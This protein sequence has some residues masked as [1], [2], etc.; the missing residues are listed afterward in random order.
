MSKVNREWVFWALVGVSISAWMVFHFSA[1]MACPSNCYIDLGALHG[2]PVGHLELD[3]TRLNTWILAWSQHALLTPGSSLFDANALYPAA[4]TLAGSEHLLG[5]ALVT[6]PLRAFTDNAV[7]IYGVALMTS[8][9]ILAFSTVLCVRWLLVSQTPSSLTIAWAAGLIAMAMPWRMAE[10][11]HIQLLWACWFP[12]IFGLALRLL[13]REG[14]WRESGILSVVLTLQLLSSYYLAYM[15]TLILGITTLV[16]IVRGGI[17]RPSLL[18]LLPPALIPYGTLGFISIPYLSRSA[19]GEISVTLDPE[20]PMAGDHLGNVIDMLLPR[21]NTLWQQNAGFETTYFIPASV[22]ALALLSCLWFGI[23]NGETEAEKP[24]SERMRTIFM[25]LWISCGVAFTMTLGSHIRL[26]ESDF[27]LPSYWAAITLP[28][29]SNL[30]APHRWAIV[31]GTLMPL[32]AA[33]GAAGLIKR[34]A[35]WKAGK[36]WLALI[37]GALLFINLPWTQL[38][39]LK[40]FEE[41]PARN[42]LYPKLR[43]LPYGPV[44]EIPWPLDS[45]TRNP[46]DS[47]YMVASTQHWRPILNGFTAHL[48]PSFSLLNRIAQSLPSRSAVERLGSLTDL[49]WVVVHWDKLRADQKAAWWGEAPGG[50]ELVFRNKE[51]AILE[52]PEPPA[53]GRWMPELLD[54]SPRNLSLSGLSREKIRPQPAGGGILSV[55]T[56]PA[57]RYMG[58]QPLFRRLEIEV[59]NPGQRT[60]PGLDLQVEGLVR[61]RYAFSKLDDQLLET[62]VLSLDTDVPPGLHTLFPTL[63]PPPESGRY[64]LCLDLVQIMDGEPKTLPFD[65][66]ELDVEV[67]G[68]SERRGD[69]LEQLA[70]TYRAYQHEAPDATQSRCALERAGVSDPSISKPEPQ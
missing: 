4:A 2:Y 53:R 42:A 63:A 30:R 69:A 45:L 32:L 21:M 34:C 55:K 58:V 35:P 43:E 50:L 62:G 66:V 49:R 16:V 19:R 52:I 41:N 17:D 33:L 65:A 67:S 37:A 48:P 3:D 11:S 18:R 51:G 12:L 22:L 15:V 57:F 1:L 68:I 46:A 60:W 5:E 44:L 7:L 31:I 14:S 28:G 47:S 61:L 23:R 29:F 26:G 27:R 10:L 8:Y 13:M 24:S 6:L 70:T 54:E 59:S 20:K 56:G 40:A 38:P 39:E 25:A 9:A 36:R 64:L